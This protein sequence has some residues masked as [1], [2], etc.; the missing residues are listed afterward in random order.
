MTTGIS[1]L[2]ESSIWF[3][4]EIEAVEEDAERLSRRILRL[5]VLLIEK[6]RNLKHGE[7][8]GWLKKEV[9]PDAPENKF[10]SRLRLA[11]KAS[12]VA[13]IKCSEIGVLSSQTFAVPV[14]A[15]PR[16][17]CESK[18]PAGRFD[19]TCGETLTQEVSLGT[20]LLL[21]PESLSDDARQIQEKFW[22]SVDGKSL[23]TMLTEGE[24][25]PLGGARPRKEKK[26]APEE[27]LELAQKLAR[28]DWLHYQRMLLFGYRLRFALLSDAEIEAQI[29]ALELAIAARKRWLKDKAGKRDAVDLE[30]WFDRETGI[31]ID[32]NCTKSE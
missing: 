10:E 8:R 29:G 15:L 28:T 12:E 27:Q 21:S 22:A 26:L 2:I 18:R 31:V 13:R 4:R 5:G 3:R 11:R 24:P 20:L 6:K 9:F 19:S 30:R 14:E 16:D 7:L 17:D 32:P 1:K 23:R 25:P